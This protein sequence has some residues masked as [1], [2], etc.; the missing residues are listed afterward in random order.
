MASA[1]RSAK[2]TQ[3]ESITAERLF[4]PS[5][6][7]FPNVSATAYNAG[8]SGAVWNVPGRYLRIRSVLVGILAFLQQNDG[9]FHV[10]RDGE[11]RWRTHRKAPPFE[12]RVG[13]V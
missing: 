13:G 2:S 9:G 5:S 10:E 7:S 8:G 11:P 12:L 4:S 3:W 1:F 6:S